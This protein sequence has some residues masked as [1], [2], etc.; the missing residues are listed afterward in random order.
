MKHWINN[1]QDLNDACK[2]L[3]SSK[4]LTMW[5]IGSAPEKSMLRKR[6]GSEACAVD[7]TSDDEDLNQPEEDDYRMKKKTHMAEKNRS[8]DKEARVLRF[9]ISSTN[10]R[11]WA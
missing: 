2:L 11:L 6:S 5:C 8:S 10:V 4:R 1:K 3:I 7:S 9:F